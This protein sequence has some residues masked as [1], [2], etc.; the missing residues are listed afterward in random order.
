MTDLGIS[1]RVST[2]INECI[3]EPKFSPDSG[4]SAQVRRSMWTH[5]NVVRNSSDLQKS[6]HLSSRTLGIGLALVAS[7][8]RI[9]STGFAGRS[10]FKQAKLE[11]AHDRHTA[12]LFVFFSQE[13]D[14]RR[15]PTSS[16]SSMSLQV[17]ASACDRPI[18]L[19]HIVP[20]RILSS[21]Q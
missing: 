19:V 11:A 9:K 17:T 20:T 18:T 10:K 6:F 15:A 1:L 12:S 2:S 21:V 14:V 4:L 5:T 8:G 3:V 7:P 16:Y 13:K